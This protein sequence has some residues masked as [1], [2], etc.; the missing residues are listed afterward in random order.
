MLTL[1][2]TLGIDKLTVADRLQLVDEIWDSLDVEPEPPLLSDAQ[3]DE[4]Q[5]RLAVLEADPTAVS[6]WEE[7]EARVL[8]RLRQ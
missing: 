8:A 6:S 1:M 5:R 4:L 3:R 2:A 7:V